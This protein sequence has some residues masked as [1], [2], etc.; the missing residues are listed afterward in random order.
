VNIRHTFSSLLRPFEPLR[1]WCEASL[2]KILGHRSIH[3]LLEAN[4]MP[5]AAFELDDS[6]VVAEGATSIPTSL[7]PFYNRMA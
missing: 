2:L 7:V 1:S 3:C 5:I 6:I 4:A